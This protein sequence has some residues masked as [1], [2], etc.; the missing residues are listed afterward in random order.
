MKVLGMKKKILTNCVTHRMNGK[1]RIVNEIKQNN[2]MY[3]SKPKTGKYEG[4]NKLYNLLSSLFNSA[5][6]SS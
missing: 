2:K 5:S 6:Y 4:V 1:R 3:K